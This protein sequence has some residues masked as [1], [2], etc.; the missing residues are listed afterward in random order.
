LNHLGIDRYISIICRASSIR[1][2]IAFPK[3]MDGQDLMSGAP[4]VISEVDKK[5]YNIQI[6]KER[7]ENVDEL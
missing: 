3:T 6:I 7:V 4:T 5:L 2:V 1:D